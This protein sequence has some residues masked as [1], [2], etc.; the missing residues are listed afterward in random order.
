MLDKFNNI[1][2]II[3]CIILLIII[4]RKIYNLD[5]PFDEN[6]YIQQIINQK[7]LKEQFNLNLIKN[8]LPTIAS[9]YVGIT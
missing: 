2:I 1:W 4:I 3:I 6:K 7:K 9:Y 8:G 5:K